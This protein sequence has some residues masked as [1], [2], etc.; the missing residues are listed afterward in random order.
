[1]P[2][3]APPPCSQ[4]QRLADLELFGSPAT[5]AA[6]A[7]QGCS[8]LRRLGLGSRHYARGRRATGVLAFSL[9]APE[10]GLGKACWQNVRLAGTCCIQAG[11]STPA[12]SCP[13]ARPRAADGGAEPA[14]LDAEAAAWQEA[15][16]QTVRAALPWV[17]EVAASYP[18]E[19]GLPGSST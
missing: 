19:H 1:M 8:A 14:Y 5:N 13:C 17:E 7:L 12:R 18:A 10:T 9:V 6:S 4:L 15:Y 16:L 11:R 2:A 3:A